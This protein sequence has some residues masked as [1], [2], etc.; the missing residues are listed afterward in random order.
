MAND[1][2]KTS[3]VVSTPTEVGKH[4]EAGGCE[5][6]LWVKHRRGLSSPTLRGAKYAVCDAF[7]LLEE[8]QMSL[9]A[10]F[11]TVQETSGGYPVVPADPFA[12]RESN[13]FLERPY[14]SHIDI[15][16]EDIPLTVWVMKLK[17]AQVA[18]QAVEETADLVNLRQG[19]DV[20]THTFETMSLVG[21]APADL[22]RRL[23]AKHRLNAMPAS[24]EFEYLA[25]V[26]QTYKS[27]SAAVGARASEVVRTFLGKHIQSSD[28]LVI[29]TVDTAP[30]L[31]IPE[32]R[33]VLM[34]DPRVPKKA[35]ID[36]LYADQLWQRLDA[37]ILSRTWNPFLEERM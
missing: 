3:V 37:V 18:R 14:K 16:P 1:T 20:A 19:A 33:N 36:A 23:V 29:G 34:V 22:L 26:V 4:V 5:R 2:E 6:I 10:L 31:F 17:G 24:L 7:A 28:T 8:D 25:D 13:P 27:D 30:K 32:T 12:P 15:Q 35:V 9:H 21:T 11:K